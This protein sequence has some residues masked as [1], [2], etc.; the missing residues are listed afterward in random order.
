MTS[1]LIEDGKTV[2]AFH[3]QVSEH[4]IVFSLSEQI[5]GFITTRRGIDDVT[6]LLEDRRRSDAQALLVV[7]DQQSRFALRSERRRP[8]LR[9]A[10]RFLIV[11]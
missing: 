6:F 4:K 1:N 7:D 3:V 8:D 10:H 5:D 2:A 11:K 9:A